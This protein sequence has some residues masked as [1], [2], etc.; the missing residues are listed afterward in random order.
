MAFITQK[1]Y[2]KAP[3]LIKKWMASVNSLR[4]D[5]Q[6]YGREYDKILSEIAERD[7]W[8]TQQFLE[9]QRDQL[10]SLI[11][12]AATNVPYYQK[13]FSEL[14]INP[15]SITSPE[16]LQH[17]PILEKEVIRVNP[18]S[19]VNQSLDRKKLLVAHT[20][21]TSGTPLNLYRDRWLN[22]AEFAYLDARWHEVVGMRRRLNK[23]VSLGGHLVTAPGRNK[24]PFWVYNHRWNQLYMSSYHLSPRYLGYYVD[25][26]RKFK[27]DYIEGYPSSV[28]AVGRYIVDN[29]LE[30]VTFKACF[31][32]AEVLFN[33]QRE[34]IEKAFGCRTYDQYGCGEQVAFAAECEHGTMHLSPDV[35]I[36]EVVDENDQPVPDGQIGQLICTSLINKVQPFI[37]YRIGDI[38][39]LGTDL[40]SCGSPLPVLKSIEGR[41][42]NV[43]ITSDGRRIGEAALSLLFYG[44]KGVVEAQIIQDDYDR[45][46]VCVVPGKDYQGADGKKVVANLAKRLGPVEICLELIEKVERTAAGK[47]KVVIC[48]ISK[49]GR[50]S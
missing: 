37:R 31:T 39:S 20:S 12:H 33:Y 21:G 3:Y 7:K 34:V 43:I 4:V 48:N 26:L 32:T 8:S 41:K 44:V 1:T 30:P 23:S 35:G 42:G 19:L 9:Y 17:L 10:K 45:F 18:L 28:Y 5:Q 46:R 47:L 27:A 36:V 38:G 16:Q 24:P 25:E 40:C 2:W 29:N 15:K 22:S 49:N 11:Q 6:R 13:I 50:V 14:G